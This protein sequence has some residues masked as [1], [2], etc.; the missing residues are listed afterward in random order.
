MNVPNVAPFNTLFPYQ[1]VH[2]AS[3]GKSFDENGC[4][5]DSSDTGTGKTYT[6]SALLKWKNRKAFVICPKP[7]VESWFTILAAFGVEILGVSNYEAI[8]NGKY[9]DT[10]EL[11][12]SDM[13]IPCPYI[14]VVNEDGTDD[15]NWD[16]P[17]DAVVI[18]DEAH[19]GKNNIT[20]NSTL[21]VSTRR[22]IQHGI[23]LLIL[24]A[25][26]TDKIECFRVAAHLLGLSQYGKHAYRAWLR[27]LVPTVP[28]ETQIQMIH[29][30][31]YP[32]Y[33]SRMRILDLKHSED[34]RINKLF[35]KNDVLAETYQMSPEAEQEIINAHDDIARATQA[36]KNKMLLET[37]PLTIILR[38]RQRIEML[39]VPTM[40][41]LAMEYMLNDNSVVI[42]VNFN[43]TITS[44]FEDLDEFV[45]KEF[46]SFVTFIQG[47]QTAEERD[48]NIKSFQSDR[49]RLM[50]ANIKAGG[51][52]VSLHDLNG[53]YPRVSII[54]PTW[55]SIDLKQ[56]LGRIYRA[57]AR[58]DAVQRIVYCK[59]KVSG[60]LPVSDLG[61]TTFH[62]EKG[63]VGI[64][65]LIAINV[66]KKLETIEWLNNNDADDLTQL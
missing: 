42:F 22:I 53:N 1:I 40:I 6:S 34:E 15:F 2:L 24:S 19:K 59:G 33:G 23:K 62:S 32:K 50:I 60:I 3:I 57:N 41:L 47:G 38:A 39:K 58:T 4:T 16:L 65:E 45:Q 56:V 36:L 21:L 31:I 29:K 46:R 25:T 49:S 9:Y 20:I 54:S 64:E 30:I 63:K 35:K 7:V 66:N 18:F 43:E 55:S 10:L 27:K 37:C 11:F 51:T 26:I 17:A 61:D 48:Y 8:K 13:R 12:R 28:G 52:G 5:L 14:E 44:L